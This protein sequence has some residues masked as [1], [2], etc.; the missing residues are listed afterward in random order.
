MSSDLRVELSKPIR[1]AEFLAAMG[2][3]LREILCLPTPVHLQC[4]LLE[5]G[6]RFE[7]SV[8]ELQ[9]SQVFAIGVDGCDD[10]VYLVITPSVF[11]RGIQGSELLSA[12]ISVHGDDALAFALAAAAAVTLARM[13]ND[14]VV[15][16]NLVW[17]ESE[18][19]GPESFL[20]KVKVAHRMSNIHVAAQEF[21]RK[22]NKH[23]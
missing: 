21:R 5:G 18:E 3:V 4:T 16:D 20:S 2:T 15:D 12:G 11:T 6:K 23:S 9:S 17:T 7:P 22:M 19:S 1:L 14:K 13:A 10:E 8:E